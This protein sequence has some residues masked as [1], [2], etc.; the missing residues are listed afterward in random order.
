M[1]HE[2]SVAAHNEALYILFSDNP[3]PEEI[4]RLVELAHVAHWHWR[5]R[6]DITSQ[7][8]SVALWLL[9]R[10]YSANGY[11]EEALRYGE[12]SLAEIDG[13]NLLPSFYGYS[14]EAI[15]RAHLLLGNSEQAQSHRKRALEIA[16]TVPDEQA[17][18]YLMDQIGRIRF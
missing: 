14:N 10:A 8:I 6:Q 13:A 9:S 17:K 11:G 2:Y 5:K 1:H 3:S 15:A 4:E 7:N 12:A 16:E 18:Q